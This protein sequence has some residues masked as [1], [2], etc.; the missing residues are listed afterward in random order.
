MIRVEIPKEYLNF[1]FVYSSGIV[2]GFSTT[3]TVKQ[4]VIEWC[5]EHWPDA[6]IHESQINDPWVEFYDETLAVQFRLRFSE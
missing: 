1:E 5:F 2:Q 3:A 4:E 6:L